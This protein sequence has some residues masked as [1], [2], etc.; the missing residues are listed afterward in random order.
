M[1]E[2]LALLQFIKPLVSKTPVR[3][4]SRVLE[5]I[6]A[7]TGR[8]TM[9][10]ISRWTGSGGSYRTI[11]RFYHTEM[12]WREILWIFFKDLLLKITEE[13]LLV[14]D[15]VVVDK[16]G[17]ETYGLGRFFSSIHQRAV[18]AISF[19][20]FSLVQVKE[21]H[22]YPVQVTQIVKTEKAAEK[23]EPG[24]KPKEK[25]GR[26]R[27]KGSKNKTSQALVLNAELQRIQAMLQALLSRMAGILPIKYLLMD[28]HFG[29]YPS[30]W[31]TRQANLH[32]ISKLRANASLYEPFTGKYKGVGRPAKYT[33]K[34]DVRKMKTKYLKETTFAD[35]IQTDIY[36][37]VLLN[38]EFQ[39]PLNVVIMLKTNLSSKAQG[40]VILFSTDLELDYKKMIDFYGLRFQIEFNFR[41][42][43]QY[44]G[45]DDF[46]NIEQ[47]ALT[48][49]ANL[50]FFLVNLSHLLLQEFRHSNSDYSLLD[51]KAHYH[52]CRYAMEAIK[53][54][55]QKPD[56]ILLADVFE[57]I[58]RLGMIHPVF[59]PSPTS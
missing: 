50:S 25:R 3:Q 15:E 56:A 43:K 34:I 54:L 20:A 17:K 23:E 48:N 16:A 57:Q 52:G 4:R 18:P 10:G 26:G 1:T 33:D 37:M 36:Q 40:Q 28:G 27:P 6:F 21:R 42:V 44:W 51:L 29:N 39:F 30:A 41:D 14:G 47:R 46:M 38:K 13:Y 24:K 8:I 12:P 5:A 32:L 59:G 49:A 11:Q 53:L 45:L 19:F 55:P 7:M 31:M 22:S 35:T 58:A 2:I 9:L